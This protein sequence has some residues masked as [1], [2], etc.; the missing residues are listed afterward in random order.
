MP[1]SRRREASRR[2]ADFA[3]N[4][5][6]EIAPGLPARRV[7]HPLSERTRQY[8]NGLLDGSGSGPGLA[9]RE[10]HY[11][12]P[13]RHEYRRGFHRRCRTTFR[14]AGGGC[15][16]RPR[17][18]LRTIPRRLEQLR[19]A[20]G[21]GNRAASR[22]NRADCRRARTEILAVQL[23]AAGER[24]RA[25]RRRSRQRRSCEHRRCRTLRR[26]PRP[27]GP[28]R[29]CAG[30]CPD[31][32]SRAAGNL[33]PCQCRQDPGRGGTI[34]HRRRG[35]AEPVVARRSRI[36]EP[37]RVAG[38][39]LGGQSADRHADSVRSDRRPASR[40]HADSPAR[41]AKFDCHHSRHA[42]QFDAAA[43]QS[44]PQRSPPQRSPRQPPRARAH[45][46]TAPRGTSRRKR[47]LCSVASRS[48]ARR[49]FRRL[50]QQAPPAQRFPAPRRTASS[51]PRSRPRAPR[52]RSA[53][54]HQRRRFP[55]YRAIS[56]SRQNSPQRRSR[57]VAT[58]HHLPPAR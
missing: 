39:R 37:E 26:R 58:S 34:R 47:R 55:P 20:A 46:T 57:R 14:A 43:Q 5:P 16:E 45:R 35:R 44:P 53:C 50:R 7:C 12:G 17:S 4:R 51:A 32:H 23:S 54:P 21:H 52:R 10:R 41:G 24:Q 6:A 18:G 40:H 22:G 15:P 42:E 13:S 56:I 3:A 49:R 19:G 48:S 2:A 27:A 25:W 36:Q 8:F 30:R 33:D 38:G 31:R 11:K 9:L 28:G 29:L 1:L